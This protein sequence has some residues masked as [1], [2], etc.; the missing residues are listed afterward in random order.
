MKGLEGLRA[1]I[2][3]MR[4]KG[5]TSSK[6]NSTQEANCNDEPNTKF[7]ETRA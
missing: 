2:D 6:V 7:E 5:T 1:T 4:C 3:A